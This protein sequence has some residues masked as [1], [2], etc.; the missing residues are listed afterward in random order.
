[1]ELKFGKPNPKQELF[2]N[3]TARHIGFGGARAGGKSWSVQVKASLLCLT[4]PGIRCLIIR[5]TYP[6]LIENHIIPLRK[7]LGGA[8]KY[9]DKEKRF[10]FGNGS[11]ITCRYCANDKDVDRFQGT[12]WDI[13]F[14]D[15]AT[16]LSEDQMTM[17]A[18]TNREVNDYPKRIYYT[19]N[20]GGQGHAYIKRIFIDRIY[21]PDEDPNDYVFIQSRVTDNYAL[22]QKNP[23]YIKNA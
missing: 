23:D 18:A 4:Y 6:E 10:T 9:N 12:Q 16:L 20:P 19:C 1:M 5:K 11:T 15:E 22:L 8:A 2:L 13:I 7:L 3:A 21:K 17:I 14:F